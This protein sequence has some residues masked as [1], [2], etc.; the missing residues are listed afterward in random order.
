VR[1]RRLIAALLLVALAACGSGRQSVRGVVIEVEGGI[2]D[3]S[4]FLLRLPDG[5]DLRLQPADGVLFHENAPIG[6]IRDHLRS[7]ESIEV[8]YEILDDGTA[9]A[10]SITD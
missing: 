2:T 5:S 8:E 9:V 3:V 10:Y 7:G 4:G 1:T 6:H